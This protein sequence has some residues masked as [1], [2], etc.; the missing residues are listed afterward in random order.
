MPTC[1]TRLFLPRRLDHAPAFAHRQRERLLDVHILAGVACHDRLD[2]MPVVGRGD[3]H[4][5][6]VFLVEDAPEVLVPLDRP[7]EFRQTRRH[8]VGERLEMRMNLVK[9]PVQVRLIDVAEGDDLGVLVS[10]ERMKVL[11]AAVTDADAGDSHAVIRPDHAAGSRGDVAA[12]RAAAPAMAALVKVRR[13]KWLDMFN[14]SANGFVNWFGPERR[15]L[16]GLFIG[17]NLTDDRRNTHV[18]R[19]SSRLRESLHDHESLGVGLCVV[20]AAFALSEARAADSTD[21]PGRG[22]RQGHHA[23]G[24]HSD[25]GLWRP[26]RHARRGHARPARWPRRS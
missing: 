15:S 6:D 2:G 4:R 24:R 7:S 22:R 18:I 8:S 3:D 10:E 11:H 17:Y 23:A 14:S 19:T 16:L 26:A 12:A 9:L 5:V 20:L 1:T 13:L 25:V 21:L